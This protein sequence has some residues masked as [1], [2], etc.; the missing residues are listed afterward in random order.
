MEADKAYRSYVSAMQ[1]YQIS[2]G[3]KSYQQ[4]FADDFE[5][6]YAKVQIDELATLQKYSGLAE[7]IEAGNLSAKVDAILNPE[8]MAFTSEETKNGIRKFWE[9]FT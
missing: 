6:I 3:R 1:N 5:Q 7:S 9:A 2:D 4:P 8:G